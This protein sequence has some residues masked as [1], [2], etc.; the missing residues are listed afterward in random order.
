MTL[1]RRSG[2]EEGRHEVPSDLKESLVDSVS[3][4]QQSLAELAELD[5]GPGGSEGGSESDGAGPPAS[6]GGPSPRRPRLMALRPS[7]SRGCRPSTRQRCC[8]E[9]TSYSRRSFSAWSCSLRSSSCSFSCTRRRN[10]ELLRRFSFTSWAKCDTEPTPRVA[11][12]TATRA[13]HSSRMPDARLEV[14]SS[15]EVLR[16]TMRTSS[17]MWEGKARR[18]DCAPGADSCEAGSAKAPAPAGRG[19]IALVAV[20]MSSGEC[21][22]GGEGGGD[23]GSACAVAADRAT[24]MTAAAEAPVEVITE[25]TR[26]VLSYGLVGQNPVVPSPCTTLM[27]QVHLQPDLE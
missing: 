12:P 3:D 27:T 5:G 21:G 19:V 22:G 14:S 6:L 9:S 8:W 20:G 24:L 17:I 4:L 25:R 10:S 16:V 23:G 2:G 26:G 15:T 1:C 7:S 13:M 18:Q 11:Q